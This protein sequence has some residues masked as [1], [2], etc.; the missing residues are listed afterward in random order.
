VM[1]DDDTP[2]EQ[3][4][5]QMKLTCCLLSLLARF[6]SWCVFLDREVEAIHRNKKKKERERRKAIGGSTRKHS[7]RTL[8]QNR[9]AQSTTHRHPSVQSP[10]KAQSKIQ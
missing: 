8:T 1:V 4:D 9:T 7:R 5:D 3:E 6:V 2:E 10:I